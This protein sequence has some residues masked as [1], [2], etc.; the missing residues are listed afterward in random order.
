VTVSGSYTGKNNGQFVFVPDAD[1]EIGVTAGLTVGVFDA[2]GMRIATLEA[3]PGTELLT[4]QGVEVAD[5]VTVKMTAGTLSATGGDVFSLDTIADSDTSDILVALGLNSFFL[6]S[7]AS[8]LRINP[9]LEN[10]PSLFAGALSNSAGDPGNVERM[11]A[12][13]DLALG[14]L[15]SNSLENFYNNVVVDVGFEASGAETI[16]EAENQLLAALE[17]ERQAV[18]GVNLDEEMINLVQYQQAF[19][20]AS[21]LINIVNE[22]TTT[23]VNLGR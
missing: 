14:D 21:R 2:S 20:A 8:D 13:R 23:I 7:R 10:S 17:D 12:L 5:G 11:L 4:D 6:G 19:Q 22:M 15:D 1:G 18:S 16:L 3:G 9:D